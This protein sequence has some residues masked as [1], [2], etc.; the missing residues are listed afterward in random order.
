[1]SMYRSIIDA[2][3]PPV[4][5]KKEM[6]K[7]IECIYHCFEAK[8]KMGEKAQKILLLCMMDEEVFFRRF[9]FN[10]KA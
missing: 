7:E 3:A 4:L 5:R 8:Y 1:M 6:E 10:P 2:R 9:L